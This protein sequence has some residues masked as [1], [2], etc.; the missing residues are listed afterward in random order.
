[1]SLNYA[2]RAIAQITNTPGAAGTS[3][4]VN[5]GDGARFQSGG[6]ERRMRAYNVTTGACE[7]VTCSNR[8][9]DT[10]TVA[11]NADGAGAQNIAPGAW[12][13]EDIDDL[14]PDHDLAYDG[15]FFTAV[16]GGTWG[17]DSADRE[18]H[19][20]QRRG[21]K[22][23]Y[24]FHGITMTIAGT[25]SEL[26]LLIPFAPTGGGAP[27]TGAAQ[28]GLCY[29]YEAGTYTAMIWYTNAGDDRIRVLKASGANFAAGV[30]TFTLRLQ[31]F[32]VEL[33]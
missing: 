33:T 32:G 14:G 21:Y 13:L 15:S 25:V 6:Q 12:V 7:H 4:V 9:T 8:V 29:G 18:R 27:V 16:G 5:T 30:N 24:E 1:M 19:S 2:T 28:R 22:L 26:G 20:W 17:V 31:A 3:F 11:R 23:D 10:F